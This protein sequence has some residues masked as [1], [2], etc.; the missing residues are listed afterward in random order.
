MVNSKS[1]SLETVFLLIVFK[2]LI[3]IFLFNFKKKYLNLHFLNL[4]AKFKHLV[5]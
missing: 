1:S 4:L 5:R 2:F 3:L